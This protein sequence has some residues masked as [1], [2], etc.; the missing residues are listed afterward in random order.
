MPLLVTQATSRL[1]GRSRGHTATLPSQSQLDYP[2]AIT[3]MTPQYPRDKGLRRVKGL[4]T[5]GTNTRHLQARGI[6]TGINT[7]HLQAQGVITG[8]NTR[9]PQAR[10][11]I[12]G[13][14]TRHLQ[15]RGVISNLGGTCQRLKVQLATGI[16]RG[17]ILDMR[18]RIKRWVDWF[19]DSLLLLTCKAS[20]CERPLNIYIY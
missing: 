19:H 7:R 3:S 15:A 12:T 18:D 2:L 10:G 4:D 6:I 17:S 16:S 14:N 8:T 20:M 5:T 13:N 1:S 11:V 9:H